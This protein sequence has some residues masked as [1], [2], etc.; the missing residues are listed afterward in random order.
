MQKL[1]KGFEKVMQDTL[2]KYEEAL[3][4]VLMNLRSIDIPN[5]A[6]SYIDDS[7]QVILVALK[8]KEGK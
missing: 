1:Y 3:K 7:I 4:E 6:D 5:A 8:L 2:L